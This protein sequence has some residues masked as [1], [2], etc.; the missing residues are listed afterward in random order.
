MAGAT[1]QRNMPVKRSVWGASKPRWKI[2][3]VLTVLLVNTPFGAA[4]ARAQTKDIPAI[5][6][7][8][9]LRLRKVVELLASPEFGGRSGEGGDKAVAYLTEQFRSLKLPGLFGGDYLQAIPGKEPG[10]RI[11]QNVGAVLRG[12]DPILRD[13]WIIL[14]A[15]FDHLGVRGGKLYPGADDN[16]S[17][18]A[19]MLEVARCLVSSATPPKRSIMFI[20]FDLEEAGLFGSRYFIVHSPVPLERVGLFITA[21]M[22]GRSLAG[23]CEEQVFLLGTE[24][25]PG[26]RPWIDEAGRGRPVSVGLLGS[27]LLVL[28]RSD[29]GPFR[30]RS[31]PFLFF[32]T[33]ENPRYHTPRDTAETLDYPKLTSIAGLIHQ[34]VCKALAAPELPRWQNNPDNPMAEAVT[35]R[36]VL[37]RLAENREKLEIGVAQIFVIN[38]TLKLLDDIVARGSIT[39]DERAR[40]IQGARIVLFTVF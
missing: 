23:V 8:E 24:H 29:Y 14:A 9:Q 32:T 5:I 1:I 36:V 18:V 26:F 34:V 40:V 20:G 15:H 10:T 11:G 19:M 37:K 39:P 38:N 30:N 16:A 17:G 35:I 28:N 7:P 31:I 3:L 6:Q 21:D 12:S 27:D 33:G 2:P 22:I 25:S 4:G 13:Q